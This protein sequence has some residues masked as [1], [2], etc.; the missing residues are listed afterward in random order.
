MGM[1]TRDGVTYFNGVRLPKNPVEAAE[2]IL[3]V[4]RMEAAGQN[5]PVAEELFPWDG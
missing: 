5:T 2:K 3:W 1:Y 4:I